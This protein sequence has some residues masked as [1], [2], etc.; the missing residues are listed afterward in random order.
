MEDVLQYLQMKNHYYEKF[1]SV[2]AKFLEM[3]NRNEWDDLEFFV[4]NRERI[5][6]IIRSFDFQ[7]SKACEKHDL[8]SP[9]MEQYR[10]R[11]KEMMDKR[12]EMAAKIVALD[13]ELISK[14]DEYKTETI[15]DL[16]KTVETQHQLDSFTKVSPSKKTTKSA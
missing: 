2:T 16:K 13:L 12:S 1:Y 8:N 11:I 10:T 15:R 14:I 5:L 6:N 7:I 4:D 3:V 9:G